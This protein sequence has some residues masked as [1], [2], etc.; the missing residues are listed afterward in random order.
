MTNNP[1]AAKREDRFYDMLE[2]RLSGVTWKEIGKIHNICGARAREIVH[3]ALIQKAHRNLFPHGV[4]HMLGIRVS[5][6]AGI[7]YDSE[8]RT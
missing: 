6:V 1:T 8:E 7:P 4:D 5:N 3:W 2:L